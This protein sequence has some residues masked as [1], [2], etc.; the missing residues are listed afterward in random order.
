VPH[1]VEVKEE[2]VQETSDGDTLYL[3]AAI[4]VAVALLVVAYVIIKRP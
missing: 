2:S 3:I 4:L 1:V